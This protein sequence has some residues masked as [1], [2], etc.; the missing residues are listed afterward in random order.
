[1]T[2]IA[3]VDDHDL[4]RMGL[5]TLID[6]TP[7]LKFVGERSNG[8]DIVPFLKETAADLVLLD[9][10]MP[11][12][13]GL[14]ALEAI[15]AEASSN[16]ALAA[17]KVLVLTTS[18]VEEDV[19]A[20]VRLGVDG[21]ALKALSPTEIV[22]AI[23]TV[24]AG[25]KFF[26]KSVQGIIDSHDAND[27]LSQREK[28][29]L[30]LMAK[31]LSNPE[32][33]RLLDITAETAKSHIKH[34]FA[35]MNV[36][37]RVEAVSLAYARGILK[38][39]FP[40]ACLAAGSLSAKD[41]LFD[42]AYTADPSPLVYKDALYLYAAHDADD[43]QRL[44][45]F[46]WVCYSTTNG[47]DWTSHGAVARAS[48]HAWARKEAAWAAE[49][50]E[51][52]GRFY[53]Y[54]T[55]RREDGRCVIGV[56]TSPTPT[57]PF[58]DPLGRPLIDHCNGD[59]DP[60]VMKDADG[61]CYL[62]WGIGKLH[63]AKLNPDMISLDRSLGEDGIVELG[64]PRHYNCGPEVWRHGKTYYM[65]YSG[66]RIPVS[67][68]YAT[69][70]APEGPWTFRGFI[71]GEN[72]RSP[73]NQVGVAEFLGRNWIFGYN[74]ERYADRTPAPRRHCERRSVCATDF[75]YDENGKLKPIS[76]WTAD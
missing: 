69:A 61:T 24:A 60:T 75:A 27:E 44:R 16:G 36:C 14:Q 59:L 41:Y 31:G 20:A 43:A 72:A 1:M 29:V 37:D 47:T 56:L 50:V 39:L 15:R 4:L 8:R 65:A 25:G 26:N 51:K 64:R 11:E 10:R 70:T 6:H 9:L 21:Y 3:I 18:D 55:T 76:F 32:I 58:R 12:V 19:L 73:S 52:D 42:D 46:D 13:D 48:D 38:L 40:I 67:I 49:A 74:Y 45:N 7:G 68:A 30:Q 63:Y 35:K 33:G 57:G 2:R 71:V 28:E 62:Y 5:K 53:L 23:K 22:E 17:L 66:R 34:I 54:T